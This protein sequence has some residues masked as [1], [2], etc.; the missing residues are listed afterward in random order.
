MT[1]DSEAQ[2]TP[3]SWRRWMN[4]SIVVALAMIA[5]TLV[6]YTPTTPKAMFWPIT[7]LS[8]LTAIVSDSLPQTRPSCR[9]P[10]E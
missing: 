6:L 8:I 3:D 9:R 4:F 1:T 5:W 2:A 10:P 7:G